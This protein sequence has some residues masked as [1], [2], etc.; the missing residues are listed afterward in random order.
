MFGKYGPYDA[1]N[2]TRNWVKESYIGIDQGP[3]VI[4]IENHRTGLLWKNV[5][6]DADVQ[7]GL[8]KLG[9]EYELVSSSKNFSKQDNFE[10]FPNPASHFI[11]FSIMNRNYNQ[12]VVLRIFSVEGRLLE[13]HQMGKNRTTFNCSHIKDGL[14]IVELDSEKEI[15][16]SKLII[17][18]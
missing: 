15:Y 16:R 11:H 6:K 1:F 4:M 8:E 10:M 14:Y 18:K 12:P 17:Q 5:M 3:I 2:D 13:T 7:A 9:F